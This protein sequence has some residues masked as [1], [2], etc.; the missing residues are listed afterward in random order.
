[1]AKADRKPNTSDEIWFN[2]AVQLLADRCGSVNDAERRLVVGMKTER[3]SWSRLLA[4]GTRV[5]GDPAFW[6][7]GKGGY[8]AFIR[9]ENR[10]F[11]VVPPSYFFHHSAAPAP[12]A[13]VKVS[14]SAVLAL[15]PAESTEAVLAP[16]PPAPS[17]KQK[18]SDWLRT[19]K[20]AFPRR[21][22]EMKT[23][24]AA[25]LIDE[26]QKAPVTHVWPQETMERR[27]RDRDEE[28]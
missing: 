23:D 9:A 16:S 7:Q 5:P 12:A 21:R 20:R 19:A 8:L 11:H 15:V 2:D 4:D 28:E 26:M 22:G 27:L 14:R 3:V 24:Y 1:M 25:R 18:P 10:I 13:G 6:K 17:V